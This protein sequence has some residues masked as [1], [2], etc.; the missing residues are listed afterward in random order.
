MRW[1][2]AGGLDAPASVRESTAQYRDEEDPLADFVD[3]R[4]TLDPD[5]FL[6]AA[7][8]RKTYGEWAEAE[9]ILHR[10]G[11]R[12]LAS[13]IAELDGVRRSA[14]RVHGVSLRGYSGVALRKEFS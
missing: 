3:D 11:D 5:G 14:K 7:E 6:P 10:L 8:L 4:L 12:K 2:A 1:H 9:G 13:R